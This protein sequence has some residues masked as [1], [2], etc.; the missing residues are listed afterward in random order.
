ML[1]QTL[2][3]ALTCCALSATAQIDINALLQN[4]GSGVQM[5]PDTDP[6]EPNA[7]IGSFRM[8]MTTGD[9]PAGDVQ[10]IEFHSSADKTLARTTGAGKA[11]GGMS[12]ITDHKG[13][14]TYM[15]MNDGKQKQAIKMKK[16]KL[17]DARADAPADPPEVTVTKE[18]KVIDGH[19]CTK[20]IVK[21]ED[22]TWTGWVAKDVNAPFAAIARSMG[23]DK[24]QNMQGMEGVAGFPLE[25]TWE[26]AN[27]SD[28]M[29]CT[30]KDLKVGKVDEQAFSLEGYQVMEMP[31][32]PAMGR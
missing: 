24:H 21:N 6:F 7:F 26:D 18:T 15:L 3:A 14:W 11:P 13:K 20:V 1:K 22:G 17:V 30:I 10:E 19:T 12:M 9:D 28:R 4:A 5:V 31:A 16:M 29:H 8:V 2:L 32:M 23:V 25:Y 27:G